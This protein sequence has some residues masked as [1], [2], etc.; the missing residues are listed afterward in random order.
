MRSFGPSHPSFALRVLASRHS[1]PSRCAARAV[2]SPGWCVRSRC[3]CSTW[4][5]P[6]SCRQREMFRC[7]WT[8][9]YR[10]VRTS[11]S[12]ERIARWRRRRYGAAPSGSCGNRRRTGGRARSG[13]WTG[14]TTS[15]TTPRT[16]LPSRRQ[17]VTST[18]RPSA[19]RRTDT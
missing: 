11:C 12:R 14:G 19:V 18:A 1:R 10:S 15:P 4:P 3:P 8:G 13:G 2:H 17:T 5:V 16:T 9:S 6:R 7:G